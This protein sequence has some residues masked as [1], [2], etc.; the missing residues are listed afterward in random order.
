MFKTGR[1]IDFIILICS[2]ENLNGLANTTP[3]PIQVDRSAAYAA[4]WVAKSLVHNG[5]CR[6]C[7]VQV[8]ADIDST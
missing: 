5:L 2:T 7:L 4:R 3:P 8:G 1:L 6:R